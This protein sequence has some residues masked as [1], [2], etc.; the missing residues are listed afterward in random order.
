MKFSRLIALLIAITLQLAGFTSQAQSAFNR[1]RT[2]ATSNNGNNAFN[3]N[4]KNNFNDY[5]YSLNSEYAKKLGGRWNNFNSFRG[6]DIPEDQK[7]KPVI[8]NGDKDNREDKE[9]VIDEVIKPVID[10]NNRPSP[11]APVKEDKGEAASS[12]SFQLFGTPFSVRV[13]AGKAFR[14]TDTSPSSLSN[15]WMEL[16]GPEYAAM[17]NDC[18]K[19]KG[20]QQMCDWA[21]LKML[22]A[23][24][25]KY[26]SDANSA[27]FLM[28]YL[29]GQSGYKIRL[30]TTE[31]GKLDMLYASRHRLLKKGYFK[32]DG[33]NFYPFYDHSDNMYIS[34]ANFSKEQPL[35]LWIP[36]EPVF[37]R[38]V[39]GGL[40]RKSDRYP[41][42]NYNTPVNENIIKFYDTYPPSYVGDNIMTRWA[43]IANT[44]MSA[45]VK[46]DLYPKLKATL[47]GLDEL[48]AVEKLLNWVQ[49]G[50]VYEYD[51]KVWGGDRA[52]FAEESLY[53]PYCDCEDRAILFT[54]LVR[55]LVGLDCILVFYPGHLAAAVNFRGD[56]SGDYIHYQNKR[57]TVT[58]PTYINARVGRTMPQMDNATAKVILLDR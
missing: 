51:D 36:K 56:V 49:T 53:Y 35:S 25:K 48:Q 13:P 44:P 57:F 41:E 24:S 10:N 5:R 4:R 45:Q 31:Q 21:Y 20:E 30:G 8:W 33:V 27:A 55:D 38:S 37:A 16:S 52:F 12:L 6:M 40:N 11:I 28:A 17:L 29:Y 22:E 58:D 54:R 23:L 18:L 50:F 43:M 1:N 34:E 42:M 7:V 3:Q 47:T 15:A 14:L 19:I 9:V 32:I 2:P 26:C 39:S 46:Q